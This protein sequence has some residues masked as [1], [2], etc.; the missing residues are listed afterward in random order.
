MP[1]QTVSLKVNGM[2]CEHCVKA[3]KDAL[4]RIKGA[5]NV[6]VDLASGTASAEMTGAATREQMAEAIR[7]AGFDVEN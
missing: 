6:R 4:S 3:V 2:S 5:K 1:Q 7:E